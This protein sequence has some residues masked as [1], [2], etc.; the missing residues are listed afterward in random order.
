MQGLRFFLVKINL[1]SFFTSG[2]LTRLFYRTIDSAT[3]ISSEKSAGFE[4]WRTNTQQKE[5]EIPV[6]KKIWLYNVT[7]PNEF[8][9][10]GEKLN[11]QE[12]G[13][14]VYQQFF[15]HYDISFY[16]GK[17]SYKTHTWF[18]FVSKPDAVTM[19]MNITVVNLPAQLVAGPLLKKGSSGQFIFN[20]VDT[21]G[22]NLLSQLYFT[23]FSV[24]IVH[25]FVTLSL[26]SA[27][28]GYNSTIFDS[29]NQIT[30]AFNIKPPT[31]VPVQ[32]VFDSMI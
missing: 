26:E 2:Y 30:K 5:N 20:M 8:L 32:Y 13:P 4:A 16:D 24:F 22:G 14:F 7:N 23:L 18:T 19:D 6:L 10:L 27:L 28:F 17:L 21:L 25:R 12:I 3:I 29:I 11:V 9:H 1:R 15:E 31:V